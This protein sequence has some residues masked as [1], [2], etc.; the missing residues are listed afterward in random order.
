[1]ENH[2]DEDDIRRTNDQ[3]HANTRDAQ[4]HFECR[5]LC[6]RYF[7]AARRRFQMKWDFILMSIKCTSA[8]AI[9]VKLPRTIRGVCTHFSILCCYAL[10]D[11]ART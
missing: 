11:D 5:N 8:C 1:M 10:G 4:V 6:T 3:R 2:D 7:V 9:V